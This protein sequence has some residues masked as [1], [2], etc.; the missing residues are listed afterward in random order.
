[1]I[2]SRQS[3]LSRGAREMLGNLLRGDSKLMVTLE[4]LDLTTDLAGKVK[5]KSTWA[6][7][8]RADQN[9]NI[10]SGWRG[11]LS[12]ELSRH[13]SGEMIHVRRGVHSGG[14]A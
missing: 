10:K 3:I 9:T 2:L 1:M 8:G 6:R 11:F 4:C 7:R 12:L 5:D 13:G 14:P